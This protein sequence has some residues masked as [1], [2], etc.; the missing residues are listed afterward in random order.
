M[1]ILGGSGYPR[2][3]LGLNGADGTYTFTY[4]D[5]VGCTYYFEEVGDGIFEKADRDMTKFKD[6][7]RFVAEIQFL[8]LDQD[9]TVLDAFLQSLDAYTGDIYVYP[10]YLDRGPGAITRPLW[11]QVLK[12]GGWGY[13]YWG[14]GKGFQGVLRFVGVKLLS[15]PWV[16]EP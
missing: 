7:V 10:R 16:A 1:T 3:D 12:D 13:D 5:F 9:S 4:K 15:Q 11:Y 14:G 2:I 6:G 8:A